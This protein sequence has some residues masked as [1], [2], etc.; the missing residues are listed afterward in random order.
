[1][2]PKIGLLLSRIRVE[3]KWLI[4]AKAAGIH[5]FCITIDKE[6]QSYLPH[7]YGEVNY[8]FIDDV[9]KLPNRITEIYR[10]LTS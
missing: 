9:R 4:E 10:R 3:E 8:I 2:T 5:P 7:M 6:A 1:M